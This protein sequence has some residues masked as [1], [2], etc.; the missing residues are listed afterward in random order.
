M[1]TVLK[2]LITGTYILTYETTPNDS[3]LDEVDDWSLE[4]RCLVLL[5]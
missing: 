1:G 4:L 5:R 3:I 2:H